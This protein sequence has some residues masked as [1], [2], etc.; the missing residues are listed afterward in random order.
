MA[1]GWEN[2]VVSLLCWVHTVFGKLDHVVTGHAG[3]EEDVQASGG[4]GL[5]IIRWHVS[6]RSAMLGIGALGGMIPD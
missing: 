1:E 3:R 2:L 4:H 5:E 6:Y